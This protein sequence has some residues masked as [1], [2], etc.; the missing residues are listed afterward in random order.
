MTDERSAAG[1]DARLGAAVRRALE[2][3]A[4]DPVLLDGLAAL[5]D[6]INGLASGGLVADSGQEPTPAREEAADGRNDLPTE[7]R[8]ATTPVVEAGPPPRDPPLADRD[9]LFASIDA[10]LASRAAES[11]PPVAPEPPA[12]G[13][14]GGQEPDIDDVLQGV[15]DRTALKADLARA[16]LQRL[17][18]GLPLAQDLLHRLRSAGASTWVA[19][20]SDPDAEALRQL[21]ETL[22]A[23]SDAA[24]LALRLRE[25]ATSE[26]AR[27]YRARSERWRPCNRRCGFR[28]PRC[29]GCPTTTRSRP[30]NG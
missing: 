21:A 2:I 6:V 15:R 29:G 14:G 11:Q 4:D 13:P 12:A 3:A 22:D 18:D 5:A 7:A 25:R 30:S 24:D 9:A 20:L 17:T 19:D 28:L 16:V 8:S 23:V 10:H 26:T 27:G 1:L